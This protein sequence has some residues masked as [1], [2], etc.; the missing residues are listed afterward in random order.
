MDHE[1]LIL[2]QFN[3]CIIALENGIQ[4]CWRISDISFHPATKR[5]GDPLSKPTGG[6]CNGIGI[7][8]IQRNDLFNRAA[9][10][11]PRILI[12]PTEFKRS[13]LHKLQEIVILPPVKS[14]VEEE[15]DRQKEAKSAIYTRCCIL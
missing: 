3:P 1:E 8:T 5:N 13:A 2:N 7:A 15:V 9:L 10:S 4:I 14:K 6:L 12:E 11:A